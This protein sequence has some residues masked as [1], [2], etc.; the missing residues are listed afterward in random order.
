MPVPNIILWS[1]NKFYVTDNNGYIIILY[2][3]YMY[4]DFIHRNYILISVSSLATNVSDGNIYINL[5]NKTVLI[6]Q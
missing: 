3:S 4:F 5:T 1:N 2:I 6:S